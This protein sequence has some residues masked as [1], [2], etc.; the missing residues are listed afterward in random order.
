MPDEFRQ[1]RRDE[2]LPLAVSNT[3]HLHSQFSHLGGKPAENEIRNE[4]HMI[5]LSETTATI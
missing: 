1:G 5:K 4:V 3:D 2:P